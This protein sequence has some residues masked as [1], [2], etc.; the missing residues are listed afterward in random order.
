MANLSFE[1]KRITTYP[2]PWQQVVII[3]RFEG[4]QCEPAV[5]SAVP[6]L[7]LD[8]IYCG[9]SAN[10]CKNISRESLRSSM[11]RLVCI[12]VLISFYNW[13]QHVSYTVFLS[14]NFLWETL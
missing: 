5:G 11:N 7:W 3:M 8:L 2:D 1:P 6:I 4:P 14:D 13:T 12:V 10:A 9:L